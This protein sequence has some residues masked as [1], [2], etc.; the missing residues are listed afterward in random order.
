SDGRVVAVV[1]VDN[2]IIVDTKDALLVTTKS[3]AQSVKKIVE[4]L[5]AEKRAELL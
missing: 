5:K 3:R 1:D 4:K 2:L